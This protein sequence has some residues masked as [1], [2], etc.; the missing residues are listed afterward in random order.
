MSKTMMAAA[1]IQKLP[2]IH[3][4]R[5]V[6]AAMVL[7][8]HIDPLTG[9]AAPRAIAWLLPYLGAGVFLF[10]VISAFS[11]SWST[12]LYRER[13][14]WLHLY[15]FKRFFRIAPLFYAV[16]AATVAFQWI[17][18][19][20]SPSV[21]ALALD[22]SFLFGLYTGPHNS[23]VFGGWTLGVEMLFYAAFPV[24]A[25]VTCGRRAACI[26][27][28]LCIALSWAALRIEP[29]TTDLHWQMA[30]PVHLQFFAA[31]IL[32]YHLTRS[33]RIDRQ[34]IVA[35]VAVLGGAVLVLITVGRFTLQ[36]EVSTR[37]SLFAPLF[38]LL[39]AWQAMCPSRAIA[40]R[41]MTYWGERSF[42][43]YLLHG[44]ILLGLAPFCREMAVQL[45]DILGFVF[46]G[47]L[48]TCAILT[49]SAITY[50]L[51]ER[52]GMRLGAVLFDRRR[53][54]RMPNP[55]AISG[56]TR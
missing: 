53:R 40:N 2:G 16:V 26:A 23:L 42:S 20:W 8:S 34:V 50:R 9:V 49:G 30:L 19:G 32:A 45:G 47:A 37:L 38:G 22:A 5:C 7:L 27:L 25:A 43:I 1:K 51:V 39:C 17:V 31:G 3:G 6:A 48:G 46:S 15:A 33:P 21:S 55:V 54:L 13:A 12:S 44:P 29:A 56:V 10:F 24:V 4:L 14:D 28:A 11:L 52:P 18:L 35:G 36:T 41:I